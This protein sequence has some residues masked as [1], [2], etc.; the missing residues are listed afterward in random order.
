MFIFVTQIVLTLCLG[1]ILFLAAHKV[2]VLLTLSTEPALRQKKSIFKRVKELN[3][4]KHKERF[5]IETFK[6]KRSFNVEDDKLTRQEEFDQEG[7][8]WTRVKGK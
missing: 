6:A 2:P 5:S 4:A 7:D 8:Y 1:G 3:L